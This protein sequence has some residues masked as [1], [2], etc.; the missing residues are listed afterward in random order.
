MIATIF[1]NNL[2]VQC[3]IGKS[4]AERRMTQAIVVTVAGV[5]EIRRAVASDDIRDTLDYHALA[6]RIR[7]LA[8]R[9]R[10]K[11]L[12]TLAARIAEDVLADQRVQRVSVR[13]EKPRKLKNCDAVG[14]ELTRSRGEP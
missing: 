7:A 5:L 8:S 3:R 11:L 12:E 14:V 2:H 1:I 13:V 9:S 4:T 6:D 10:C